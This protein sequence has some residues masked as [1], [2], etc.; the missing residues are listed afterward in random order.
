MQWD[1]EER[2]EDAFVS[3]LQGELSGEFRVSAALANAEPAY[4][5]VVVTAGESNA[6]TEDAAWSDHRQL[7][8]Q[9]TVLVEAAEANDLSARDHNARVR[10]DVLN[11]LARSDLVTQIASQGVQAVAFSQADMRSTTRDV[12]NRLYMTTI[13]IEVIAEPVTGS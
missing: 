11:A 9:V 2:T 8:V 4:P 12:Q 10:S 5:A 3:Y 6:I 13:D 7:I 1:L